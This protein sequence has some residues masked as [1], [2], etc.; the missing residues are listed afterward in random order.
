MAGRLE[1]TAPRSAAEPSRCFSLGR[2]HVV[3]ISDDDEP[4]WWIYATT[5]MLVTRNK[6][7]LEN[8]R[9]R[10]VAEEPEAANKSFPLWTDDYAS[11]F[12]IMKD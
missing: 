8:D 6:E 1:P 5:W 2:I 12:S 4:E 11:L 3:T 9:I 7:F 10:N